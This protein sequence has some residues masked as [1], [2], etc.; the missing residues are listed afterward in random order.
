MLPDDAFFVSYCIEKPSW[1][2]AESDTNMSFIEWRLVREGGVDFPQ[3]LF[4]R[5]KE[6]IN[7]FLKV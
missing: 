4:Q 5:K 2:R 3:Y 6:E 7:R 1:A